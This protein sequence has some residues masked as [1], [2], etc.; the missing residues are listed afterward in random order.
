MG[1]RATNG[2]ITSENVIAAAKD[3]VNIEQ[4][5]QIEAVINAGLMDLEGDQLSFNPSEGLSVKAFLTAIA[6]GLYGADLEI[7]HLQKALDDGI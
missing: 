3:A 5:H 1:Y 2:A 6:K 7:D 4:S